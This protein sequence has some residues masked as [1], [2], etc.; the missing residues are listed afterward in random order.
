MYLYAH[1][2][3]IIGMESVL[4]SYFEKVLVVHEHW[5]HQNTL[6]EIHTWKHS[7]YIRFIPVVCLA[8]VV[9]SIHLL[10]V[11]HHAFRLYF[12]IMANPKKNT[13][14]SEHLECVADK[15]RE[16]FKSIR[17]NTYIPFSGTYWNKYWPIPEVEIHSLHYFFMLTE[18]KMS[19]KLRKV[20]TVTSIYYG[21]MDSSYT[22]NFLWYFHI[23]A[24]WWNIVICV[25]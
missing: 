20:N 15:S 14:Y 3:N 17:S 19:V 22:C 7:P 25:C 4:V 5:L 12:S 11:S 13:C 16:A 1:T 24:S 6:F 21:G 8:W 9:H 18:V 10:P 2:N 23:Y